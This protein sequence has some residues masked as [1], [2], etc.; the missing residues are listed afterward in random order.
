MTTTLQ[1]FSAFP[2]SSMPVAAETCH[3]VVNVILA[4]AT[5]DDE[6]FP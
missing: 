5:N 6:V 1:P 4:W 2:I 3:L